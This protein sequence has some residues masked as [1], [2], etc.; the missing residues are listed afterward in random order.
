MRFIAN[1]VVAVACTAALA[2]PLS[3]MAITPVGGFVTLIRPCN[4]G[5]LLTVV[6]PLGVGSGEYMWTPGTVSFLFGPP[7]LHTWVLGMTDA[8]LPCFVGATPP[9]LIGVGQR[10]TFHGTSLPYAKPGI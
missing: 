10:I 8:I 2:F 1:F 4:T 5:Y 9:I 3:A 7:I 6:N